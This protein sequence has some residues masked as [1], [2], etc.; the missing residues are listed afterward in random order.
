MGV[1][2][3]QGLWMRRAG[4]LWHKRA[5]ASNSSEVPSISRWNSLV[6]TTGWIE[7]PEGGD[8]P[9]LKIEVLVITWSYENI[10]KCVFCRVKSVCRWHRL[11]CFVRA[12]LR[13]ST[14]LHLL[15]CKNQLEIQ[16]FAQNV[17]YFSTK[18]PKRKWNVRKW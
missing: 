2:C 14:S 3:V 17:S 11:I 4:S 12:R 7:F 10:W 16:M 8:S 1:F 9:L 6:R 5:C 18:V 15:E 13:S